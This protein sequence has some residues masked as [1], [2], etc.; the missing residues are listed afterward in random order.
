MTW[1][2]WHVAPVITSIFF[3]LG[4]FTLYQVAF[5]WLRNIVHEKKFSI[6]D[7]ILRSSFG[8]IYMLVFIFSMQSTIVGKS[9]SW[10][11]MNFIIIALIFCAYFLNIRVPL[12]FFVPIILIY[13]L[14][15]N[16]LG[17]W[18]SWL[19]A[20]SVMLTYWSF[21]YIRRRP[22]RKHPFVGYMVVG[23]TWGA[24][25]WFFVAVKFNLSQRV[26]LQEW[27]Y[28]LIFEVLLYSY[29]RMLLRENDLKG[30]LVAFANHDA[31][32]KTENYAAY[33]SEMKLLFPNSLRNKLNLSMM[34]F[35]I[36][37]F[38]QVNDTYG[39]LAGDKVLQK[40]VTVAQQVI[41]GNDPNVRLYR[42]GGEEF[43]VVFPGYDLPSTEPIVRQ[44]FTALNNLD[45][46]DG[47]KQ[48]KITISVGVS[49]MS[50]SD[51]NP[52][53]FYKRVDNN[54]YHSKKNGRMQITAS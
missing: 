21:N 24:V 23:V 40:A 4:V 10:E 9:I 46:Q 19:H 6:N 27:S 37:H 52:D 51:D 1:D 16:S 39:H 22:V 47:E 2:V 7:D 29:M 34:M 13:M 5:D 17:Y 53:D 54:L 35:D 38:K 3:I 43:N 49:S 8:V 26:F 31:L 42:T 25:M 28:L 45:I 15:N 36:D 30:R 41:D 50:S 33:V 18:E 11:F 44:I 48:I 14:F 32:T 12:Y 20:L